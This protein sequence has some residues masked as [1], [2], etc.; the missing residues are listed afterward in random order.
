MPRSQLRAPRLQD[1]DAERD[2]L[3]VEYA[4]RYIVAAGERNTLRD[5]Y[6]AGWDAKAA[7]GVRRGV[8]GDGHGHCHGDTDSHIHSFT[9]KYSA[10]GGIHQHPGG[11]SPHFHTD[12]DPASDTAAS[13]ARAAAHWLLRM[14]GV[15][16]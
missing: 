3:A 2:R 1:A 14:L 13:H 10:Y 12:I 8:F 9:D 11:A 4:N 6:R 16:R 5:A 15:R 7:A